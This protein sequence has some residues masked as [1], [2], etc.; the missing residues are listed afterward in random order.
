VKVRYSRARWL[1]PVPALA[2]YGTFFVLLTN[3]IAY[4]MQ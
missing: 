3:L 2:L 4:S 1:F